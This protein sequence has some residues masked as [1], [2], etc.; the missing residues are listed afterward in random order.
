MNSSE[1]IVMLTHNDY[2]VK[3]A[4]EIFEQCKDSNVKYWGFKDK[5]LPL[6][7]MKELFSY[8]KNCKKI[9]ILEIVE[10]TEEKCMEGALLARECNCDLLMGTVYFESVNEF[11]KN[12]N[13]KYL[14]FAGKVSDR[15][16]V[17]NG[18][19]DEILDEA[20]VYLNNGIYGFDL[21][22]Y[23]YTGDPVELI[24]EFVSKI[25]VPVC[26]AGSI[27]SYERL[28]L[29]KSLSPWAFTIGGAFFENKFGGDFKEQIDKVQKYINLPV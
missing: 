18:T 21:L 12:N 4:Y 7:E 19:I 29:I 27:D 15:P 14:P 23:R 26:V 6:T 2:T 24:T 5:G 22:G 3:N 10:Y 17:L 13:L 11:C 20:Q 28:D 25:D 8:M 1:L 9:T 16:S